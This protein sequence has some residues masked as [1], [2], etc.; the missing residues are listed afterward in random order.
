[1]TI[2]FVAVYFRNSE[3]TN[4]VISFGSTSTSA[5]PNDTNVRYDE[6]LVL[7]VRHLHLQFQTTPM[8]GGGG[9]VELTRSMLINK[10]TD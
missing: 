7:S 5:I 6:G 8:S 3:M 2:H 1:M 10:N 4:D 9:E